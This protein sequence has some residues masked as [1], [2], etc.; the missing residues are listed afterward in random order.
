MNDLT[1]HGVSRAFQL[2]WRRRPR[3]AAASWCKR[4]YGREREWRSRVAEVALPLTDPYLISYQPPDQIDRIDPSNEE[5]EHGLW[6]A[7]ESLWSRPYW[8]RVWVLSSP[9]ASKGSAIILPM[10][11]FSNDTG[12][13]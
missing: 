13:D 9:G 1:N 11:V 12:I 6:N 5:K 8:R 2:L 3:V 7:L 10:R 4:R